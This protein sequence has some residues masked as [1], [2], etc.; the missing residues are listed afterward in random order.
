MS[1][2][3]VLLEAALLDCRLLGR[4]KV[5]DI[6]EIGGQLLIIATDRISAFD[7]ILASGIPDKGKVLTQMSLFWFD[8]VQDIVP[9]H[10]VTAEAA[11]YPNMLLKYEKELSGR[12][13]LVRKAKPMS[14]ECVVRGYLSGSG[15]K[16]YQ[17]NQSVC[18]I[19][20]PAGLLESSQLPEPI[21]TPSTKAASGH[22]ENISFD[23]VCSLV[24]KNQAE[25]LRDYSLGIYAKAAKYAALRGIIIA[26]TKFEFG[27]F[28]N[29]IIL[30]DEALTP[31]SSRFW[32]AADYAP[33]RSQKSFDKQFVRDYLEEIR[34]NKQPPAPSLP[35]WVVEG[36]SRKY[37]EAYEWLTGRPL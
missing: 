5:R 21:F 30:I 29:E 37:R 1:Q 36:T 35:D 26:D 25:K 8:F 4:G 19:P 14:V 2:E 3:K 22:D 10:L 16:D 33:G 28:E 13:M 9:N 12:S 34:W 27:I 7:Y 23:Q 31:D 24:G 32:P 11:E 15:W 6:Y 18:G 17:K 20:L